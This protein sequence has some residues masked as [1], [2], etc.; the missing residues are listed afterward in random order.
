MKKNSLFYPCLI[1][2]A[3]GGTILELTNNSKGN[4]AGIGMI[5]Y[6]LLIIVYYQIFPKERRKRK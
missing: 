4:T 2:G 1:I 6:L 3:L 5:I